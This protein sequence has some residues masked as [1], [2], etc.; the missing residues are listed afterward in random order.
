MT[1]AMDHLTVLREYIH[2]MYVHIFIYIM[3]DSYKHKVSI[4][5]Y[6][7]LPHQDMHMHT[8]ES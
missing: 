2:G 6:A 5:L 1:I 4:V 8:Y 7:S 3:Y